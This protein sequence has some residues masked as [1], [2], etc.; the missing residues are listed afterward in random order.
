MELPNIQE[1]KLILDK[2]F[3]TSHDLRGRFWIAFNRY[4]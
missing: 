3:Y 2:L 1:K 4:Q